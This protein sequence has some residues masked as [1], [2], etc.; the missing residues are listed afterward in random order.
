MTKQR[1]KRRRCGARL[2]QNIEVHPETGRIRS[3]GGRCRAWAMKG[4]TRCRMHGGMSTG[5]K[6]DEGMARTVAAAVE[7]RRRWVERLKAEGKKVPGGR[8]SGDAWFTPA[9]CARAAIE[10]R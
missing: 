1:T 3:K 4:K 5:P 9:M 10:S 6:T 8:K 7:G 2:K